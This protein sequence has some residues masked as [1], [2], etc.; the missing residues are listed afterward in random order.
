MRLSGPRYFFPRRAEEPHELI[1][2][3]ESWKMTGHT[4][5]DFLLRHER[6]LGTNQRVAMQLKNLVRLVR[7]KGRA[8]NIKPCKSAKPAAARK[9]SVGKQST[10][11]HNQDRNM[12]IK[13]PPDHPATSNRWKPAPRGWRADFW[14]SVNGQCRFTGLGCGTPRRSRRRWCRSSRAC[15]S[16]PR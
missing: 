15:R 3:F 6:L 13:T 2:H 1:T 9:S 4:A 14:N 7:Q 8:S 5:D 12:K 10:L 16:S 11:G